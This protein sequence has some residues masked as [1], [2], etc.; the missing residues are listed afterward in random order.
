M[1]SIVDLDPT[2]PGG[3]IGLA[4]GRSGAGVHTRFRYVHA[5]IPCDLR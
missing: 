2:H 1:T 3:I 4:A 5:N